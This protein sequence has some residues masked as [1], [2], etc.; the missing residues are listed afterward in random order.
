[1]LTTVVELNKRN[2]ITLPEA[3]REALGVKPGD[4]IAIII[5][6]ENIQLLPE[7]KVWS[8]YIYGLGK[9]MWETLGGSEQFLREERASW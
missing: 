2:Q 7:P 1:M 5:E 8:E 9:S 4:H 6:G 3:A